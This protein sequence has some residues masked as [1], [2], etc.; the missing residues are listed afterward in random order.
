MKGSGKKRDGSVYWA[1]SAELWKAYG[2]EL[3]FI[4]SP[5]CVVVYVFLRLFSGPAG[6]TTAY[7]TLAK[8]ACAS[9]I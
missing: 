7:P 5:A 4:A 8:A 6:W 2:C 3:P 1:G 9:T